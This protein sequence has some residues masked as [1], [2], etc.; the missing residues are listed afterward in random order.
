MAG[1]VVNVQIVVKAAP[2]QQRLENIT[3]VCVCVLGKEGWGAVET[4]FTL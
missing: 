1:N 3:C 4:V 2:V